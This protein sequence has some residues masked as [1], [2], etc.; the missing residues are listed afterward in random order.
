MRLIVAKNIACPAPAGSDKRCV[1]FATVRRW[2]LSGRFLS[3][4]FR[5]S[6]VLLLTPR[7]EYL[8]KPF[9]T[10]V[11]MR[12]LSRGVCE[13]AATEQSAFTVG[14]MDLFRRGLHFLSDWPAKYGLLR[15]IEMDVR[16][17]ENEP[18]A[19]PPSPNL[20]LP[21]LYFRTDILFGLVSGGSVGHIAG[22][23]NNLSSFTGAPVFLTTD[24]I[25]TVKSDIEAVRLEPERRFWDF[26]ELPSFALNRPCTEAVERLA[27]ERRFSFV[28]QRYSRNNFAGVLSS[29]RLNVPFVLEYNGSEVWINRH[30]GHRLPY[31][32]LTERIEL[33]CL[34]SAALVVVVSEVL[35][36]ELA[37]RGIDPKKILVNPNGVDPQVYRP[38]VR[39]EDIR[40]KFGLS[41]KTVAGFIGTFGRWHGAEILAAAVEPAVKKLAGSGVDLH[42]LFI[43]DGPMMPLVRETIERSGVADRVHFTGAVPQNQGP[44]HLAACDILVSPHV[45][46]PDGTRFFG[47]PTK[48][49]EYMAMGKGIVA[50]DL[51][52]IGDVLEHNKNAVLVPPN[53]P[54]ALSYGIALLAKDEGLRA[55]LGAAAREDVIRKHTWRSHVEKI[56]QRLAANDC[57]L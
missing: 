14:W 38:E 6:K 1:D 56:V 25:A 10:L 47:S 24:R 23:L 15:R 43:G 21:P 39:G 20:S 44:A 16:R 53:D 2:F 36:E 7:P 31:E 40:A 17:L 49:F 41:G 26:N 29:R 12:L 11:L 9:A 3:H 5:Y 13:I 30:W 33:I 55:R 45:T 18:P 42:F 50:S 57:R 27:R 52:Q 4:L 37:G 34:R 48:L 54:E 46:N 32:K 19:T 8:T 28:Y 22:V 51:E 35:K